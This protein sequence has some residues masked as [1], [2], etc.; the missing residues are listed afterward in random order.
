MWAANASASSAGWLCWL[1]AMHSPLLVTGKNK[2]SQS[3]RLTSL[4]HMF[5]AKRARER[6]KEKERRE[7]E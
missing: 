4:H 1:V 6:E 2:E 7:R 3:V 5:T